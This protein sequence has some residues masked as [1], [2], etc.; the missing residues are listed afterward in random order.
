MIRME[1]TPCSGGVGVAKTINITHETSTLKGLSPKG[2]TNSEQ[3]VTD[4]IK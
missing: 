3:H 2:I 4:L 1:A